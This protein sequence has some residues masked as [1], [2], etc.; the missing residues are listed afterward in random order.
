MLERSAEQQDEDEPP[1]GVSR[2]ERGKLT[3]LSL[4]PSPDLAMYVRLLLKR[5]LRTLVQPLHRPPALAN[6]SSR[7]PPPFLLRSCSSR[8]AELTHPLIVGA[9][10]PISP[11]LSACADL[12]LSSLRRLVPVRFPQLRANVSLPLTLPPSL[13]RSVR[14]PSNGRVSS[15]SPPLSPPVFVESKVLITA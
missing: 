14:S 1:A 9:L 3:K 5:P 4:P 6:P 2:R 10:L 7:F 8:S 13:N 11:A 15:P 12:L